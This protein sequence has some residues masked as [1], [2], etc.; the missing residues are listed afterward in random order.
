MTK[1]KFELNEYHRNV[2]DIEL[3]EDLKRVAK[4]LQQNTVTM[5]DY[6]QY[7]NFHATTLTRR[8]GSWFNCLDKADLSP[9]RSKIGITDEELFEEIESMWVRLGKQPTY[10]QMRDMSKYSVGTYER[11][12][13]GW[14]N[15]LIAFVNYTNNYEGGTNNDFRT[16][17]EETQHKTSRTINLHLILD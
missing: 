5:D 15:S 17:Y 10:S 2:E 13:G 6:N 7:G 9:S 8:F 16:N 11:H 12:F 3:I 4:L 1:L 14:R